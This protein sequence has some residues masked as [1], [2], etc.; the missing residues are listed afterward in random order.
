MERVPLGTRGV[1][2]AWTIQNFPPKSPPYLGETS[3]QAFEPYGVGYVTLPE[4]RVEARL[5]ESR[6]EQLESGM[7]MRLVTVP[8]NQDG[9][10]NEI[11]TFAFAPVGDGDE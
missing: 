4:V 7:P 5:T 2:W 3:P 10:G 8:L 1:L 9:E 6:P 11:V